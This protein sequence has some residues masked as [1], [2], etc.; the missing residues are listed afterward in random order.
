MDDDI[1]ERLQVLDRL[2]PPDLMPRLGTHSVDLPPARGRGRLF[3]AVLALVLA[4]G[5]T[6]VAYLAFRGT[7]RPAG[8]TVVPALRPNGPI[9]FLGAERGAGGSVFGPSSVYSIQP[10]GTGIRKIPL[11]DRLYSMTAL[12]VSPDGRL[13][14]LSNG[15]GEFPPR[16]IYVMNSDGTGLRQLTMGDFEES[17][18]S[19]APDGSEIVFSSTRCCDS[20]T[21]S[22]H[23][24][25][26]TIRPDGTG[27]RRLTE[28]DGT[29]WYPAWSP[30][31]ARIA[32]VRIPDGGPGWQIWVVNADGTG[33]EPF[34]RDDRYNE[35]VTWSPDGRRLAYATYLPNHE[36]WQIRVMQADGTGV[37]TVYRCEG[38]C[39]DGGYTLAWSPDG[40]AIAF[41]FTRG[42]L[43][44]TPEIGL[45]DADGGNFRTVDTG[46]VGA[47][48]LSWIA[49]SGQGEATTSPTPKGSTSLPGVGSV[50]DLSKVSGD[51][52]GEGT[53][54][55]AYAYSL[56][57]SGA[58]PE[59][60]VVP[61]PSYYLGLDAGTGTV[62]TTYGPLDPRVRMEAF[63]AADLDGDGSDEI[64]LQDWGADPIA[65]IT[66][67]HVVAGT[68]PGDAAVVKPLVV[69][70]PGDPPYVLPGPLRFPLG[71]VA[72]V[73]YGAYCTNVDG[74]R[75]GLVAWEAELGR[76]GQPE[77]LHET[78]LTIEGRTAT[79]VG[80]S[81]RAV[82]SYAELPPGQ[83]EFCGAGS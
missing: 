49:A 79:V 72:T 4:V 39:Y 68:G 50:C 83:A 32:Y 57:V 1:R 18:P 76:D 41:T 9:W 36:D 46:T 25:L 81:D 64:A 31:G 13:V 3:A 52:L 61:A 75:P 34:T 27:L 10:D 14:A 73:L 58:C 43:D 2:E 23:D 28:D 45:V 77:H 15:G 71:G 11:P 16:N 48:C 19:W 63:A 40:T 7:A 6:F 78:I 26:Y 66:A 33:A 82:T 59:I 62:S 47:C 22:G 53:T 65:V 74:G 80:T 5:A 37:H 42:A 38:E 54:G 44:P 21:S 30:D 20:S 70:G 29:D 51:F 56:P 67:F 55:T 69:S 24:A 8:P 60:G 35:T 17:M 12:A